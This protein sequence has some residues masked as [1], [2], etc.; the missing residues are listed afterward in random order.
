MLGLWWGGALIEG[1]KRGISASIDAFTTE[2]TA[3]Y[4]PRT[5]IEASFD[6]GLGDQM[7]LVSPLGWEAAS[8]ELGKGS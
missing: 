7:L 3:P 2:I 1:C 8:L 4:S 5:H 6:R